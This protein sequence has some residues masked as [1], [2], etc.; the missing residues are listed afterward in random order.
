M[1]GWD[2]EVKCAFR[3]YNPTH[4]FDIQWFKHQCYAGRRYVD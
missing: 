4:F 1:T 3:F 2:N